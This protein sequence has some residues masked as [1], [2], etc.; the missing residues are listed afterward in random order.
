MFPSIEDRLNEPRF[1]KFRQLVLPVID[2]DPSV[3]YTVLVPLIFDPATIDVSAHIIAKAIP[4]S[5]VHDSWGDKYSCK[6]LNDTPIT[7]RLNTFRGNYVHYVDTSNQSTRFTEWDILC[8]NGIIHLIR[9]GFTK[10]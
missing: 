7:L 5:I 2:E 8:N 1:E 10:N 3:N 4:M 6:S 9:E